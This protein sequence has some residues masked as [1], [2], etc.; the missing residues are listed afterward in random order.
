MIKLII[1][2]QSGVCY[3]EEEKPFL[4]LFAEREGIP[5]E[6]LYG[7]HSELVKRAEVEEISGKE[8]WKR[9]LTRYHLKLNIPKIIS[10]MISLKRA[11]A[12][13]LGFVQKLRKKYQVAYL[14]NYNRDYWEEVKKK[15]DPSPYFDYGIVSYQI[16][17]RKPAPEGFL[18]IMKH[19]QVKPEE[20]IF[21]DDAEKNLVAAKE[22]NIKTILFKNLS[23]LKE[24]LERLGIQIN[25]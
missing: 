9:I 2:D 22:L 8:I 7:L 23:Q 6:K 24:E 11:N 3:N 15:F 12:E 21:I 20:T 14:T 1:F 5:F 10:E 19:F 17:A 18:T 16:K 25:E 13:V 4:E